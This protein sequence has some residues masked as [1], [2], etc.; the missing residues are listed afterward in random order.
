MSYYRELIASLDIIKQLI[1]GTN[2]LKATIAFER[3]ALAEAK[4]DLADARVAL[5]RAKDDLAFVEKARRHDLESASYNEERLQKA[6]NKVA[7]EVDEGWTAC[8]EDLR[9]MRAWFPLKAAIER[10]KN[11]R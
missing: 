11:G 6:F 5:A 2:N 1:E 3:R 9:K 4:A 8:G 10:L 7:T